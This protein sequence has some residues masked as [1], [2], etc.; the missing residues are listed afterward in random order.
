MSIELCCP[1]L[2]VWKCSK[3]RQDSCVSTASLYRISYDRSLS[4]DKVLPYSSVFD[5][6]VL[7][8]LINTHIYSCLRALKGIHAREAKNSPNPLRKLGNRV[9]LHV[10]S[11]RSYLCFQELPQRLLEIPGVLC[12]TELHIKAALRGKVTHNVSQFSHHIFV[13]ILIRGYTMCMC[14]IYHYGTQ[15]PYCYHRFCSI[16]KSNK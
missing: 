1:Y 8:T 16:S 14:L 9:W 7:N 12:S 3:Y 5:I 4:L 6:Q 10:S 2:S 13:R 11:P 15:A